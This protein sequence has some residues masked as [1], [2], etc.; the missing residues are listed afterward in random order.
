V[1]TDTSGVGTARYGVGALSYGEDKGAF[2]WGSASG[3]GNVST[4]NL[5]NSSG[6]IGSDVTGV[7]TTRQLEGGAE[8]GN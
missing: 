8:F 5:V 1:A 7:G 4:K 6:V 3:V 2:A